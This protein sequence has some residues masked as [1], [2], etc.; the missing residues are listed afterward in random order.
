MP[1]SVRRKLRQAISIHA[2]RGEDDDGSPGYII[3]PTI[4]IHALR[5]EDDARA[6]KGVRSGKGIS[7]HALRG[8]DDNKILP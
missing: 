6:N 8:E 2:L 4:S 1:P 5:G 3:L 7:I